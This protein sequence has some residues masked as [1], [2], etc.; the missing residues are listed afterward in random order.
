MK[1]GVDTYTL[2]N[3]GLDPLGVLQ[4]ARELGLDGVLFEL[5]PFQSFRDQDLE[6][7]RITAGE[8]GLH[9]EF[10]MGS[11]F[12]GHPM[13]EKGRRL[14]AEAGYNT[15]VSE[16]QTM[17]Q[18]LEV[19]R[20]LGSSILRC[21]AGDLFTRDAG[22]DM[23]KLAD[24]AVTILREACRVAEEMGMKVAMENHA[25]FTVRELASIQ[26]RVHSPAFG[27]TVD[28]ANL[29][30]DMDEP[31]RLAQIMAP[32][33]VTTHFKNYR[34]IRTPQGLALENCALADGDID[35]VAM[36]EI[37]ARYHPDLYLNIEIHSQFAPFPLDILRPGYWDRHPSPP[38]DGLSWYLAK[39]WPRNDP[40]TPPANLADGPE[41]WQ[42]ERKHLEDSIVWAK[43]K[44]AHLLAR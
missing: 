31:L 6:R 5:S 16:A 25:D 40:P 23:A 34:V 19:A 7:I 42:L 11:I 41:S 37:L 22:H 27:F 10:G 12:H 32:Y 17:K 3:S 14:L 15:D 4:S 38:G 44:L 13:A 39:S 35:Q 26:A 33:A 30:F 1:L 24:D 28:T 36:A 18:H 43:S 9:I 20:K 8:L 29:A 2:R 21:V